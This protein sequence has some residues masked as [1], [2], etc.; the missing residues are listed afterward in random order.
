MAG[1]RHHH[2]PQLLQRGFATKSGKAH[3][4]YVYKRGQSP[5]LT[6]TTNY[7]VE[8]DFY[9]DGNDFFVDDLITEYEGDIQ[10][11]VSRLANGDPEALSDQDTIGN[12]LAHLE[13]RSSFLRDEVSKISGFVGPFVQRVFS[14]KVYLRK[15]GRDIVREDPD[16]I[17]NAIR[18]RIGENSSLDLLTAFATSRMDSLLKESSEAMVSALTP[19]LEV[20]ANDLV[21]NS[22]INHL[23]SFR[24]ASTSG[25]RANLYKGLKYSIISAPAG[26]FILPDTM[27]CFALSDGATP[28]FSKD[29]HLNE[30]LLPLASST[31]L[32]GSKVVPIRRTVAET[33]SLLASTS[34]QAFIALKKDSD[35]ERLTRRIGRNARM[36]TE[37]DMQKA[38][39]EVFFER[40]K[41]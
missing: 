11:F 1:R 16:F 37:A 38:F 14:D 25:I 23:D 13:L 7:G 34:M 40:M 18:E 36:L 39:R 6:N 28:F 3:Q 26:S 27:V 33:N 4:I 5:F 10:S 20:F 21:K 31:L 41:Q 2:V 15:I 12:L 9:A 19:L 29:A 17:R 35:L 32:V 8:K 30:V 24:K 22:K